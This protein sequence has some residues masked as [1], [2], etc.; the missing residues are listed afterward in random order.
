MSC[1]GGVLLLPIQLFAQQS[2]P[3]I[4]FHAQTD[5]FKLPPELYLGEA[6][7]VAVIQKGMFSFS[8]VAGQLA[9][10]M[11]QRRPSCSNLTP[12]ESTSVK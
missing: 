5:F 2:V 4:R 10:P 9:E 8:L 3:E 12:T 1:I 7:G 6:A 11:A